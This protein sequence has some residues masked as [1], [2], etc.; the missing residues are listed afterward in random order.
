MKIKTLL[1][2]FALALPFYLVIEKCSAVVAPVS[3]CGR[4]PLR[5][6]LH[7]IGNRLDCYFTIESY[8]GIEFKVPALENATVLDLP[9]NDIESLVRVLRS[10]LI[11]VDVERTPRN[12]VV[13]HIKDRALKSLPLYNLNLGVDVKYKGALGGVFQHIDKSSG[14]RIVPGAGVMNSNE[15]FADFVTV[16]NFSTSGNKS[17]RDAMTEYLPLSQYNRVLWR[18]RT[19][20]YMGKMQTQLLHSGPASFDYLDHNIKQT[21][22]PFS[23][24][25]YAYAK[26]PNT[27]QLVTDA[28]TFIDERMAGKSQLNVRW[29][30][31][32]LGKHKVERGVPTLLQYIDYQY[33]TTP[34]IEESYPAL[35]ALRQIGKPA[36]DAAMVALSTEK[37][38]KRLRLLLRV[39]MSVNGLDDGQKL[40]NT[41]LPT[42]KDSAQRKRV[43]A[44]MVTV[45]K[46]IPNDATATVPDEDDS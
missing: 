20:I 38:A 43:A 3:S 8:S 40:V 30:M 10:Q 11:N 17:L 27:D 5:Q 39:V 36:S 9:A 37:D 16:V 7:T 42:F 35:R 46:Q 31:F 41:A 19:V 15:S 21:A 18:A 26:N 28:I 12:Q 13:V 29:A 1:P 4:A 2:I 24:G 34:L 22:L 23:Q 44:E 6:Y 33:T 14:V 25:I 32:Y 45:V